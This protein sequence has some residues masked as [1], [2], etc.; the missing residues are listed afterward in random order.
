MLKIFKV[1]TTVSPERQ[2]RRDE[3]RRPPPAQTKVPLAD[4][5]QPS[6]RQVPPEPKHAPPVAPK[7]GTKPKPLPRGSRESLDKLDREPAGSLNDSFEDVPDR[8]S[9]MEKMHAVPTPLAAVLQ[10]S[11][12]KEKAS[13]DED[14]HST[15]R[16]SVDNYSDDMHHQDDRE[17]GRYS[18]IKD[19]NQIFRDNTNS[20]FGKRSVGYNPYSEIPDAQKEQTLMFHT[21]NSSAVSRDK[22]LFSYPS[23]SI[24]SILSHDEYCVEDKDPGSVGTKLHASVHDLSGK[25]RNRYGRQNIGH[26]RSVGNLPTKEPLVETQRLGHNMGV[27]QEIDEAR[28]ETE[29]FRDKSVVNEDHYAEIPARVTNP[30]QRIY[31][32]KSK[33]FKENQISDPLA[34]KLAVEKTVPKPPETNTI[35]KTKPEEPVKKQASFTRKL[36][37]RTS[38]IFKDKQKPKLETSK[39]EVNVQETRK[40]PSVSAASKLEISNVSETHNSQEPGP[41]TLHVQHGPQAVVYAKINKE[42]KTKSKY[43]NQNKSLPSQFDNGDTDT[44]S[45]H[46]DSWNRQEMAEPLV[47]KMPSL[48]EEFKMY[49]LDP[50]KSHSAQSSL[51]SSLSSSVQSRGDKNSSENKR[52]PIIETDNKLEDI[53]QNS[54]ILNS[55]KVSELNVPGNQTANYE[56]PP[57]SGFE[58]RSSDNYTHTLTTAEADLNKGN[59]DTDKNH[60]TG[61]NLPLKTESKYERKECAEKPRVVIGEVVLSETE[62]LDLSEVLHCSKPAVLHKLDIQNSEKLGVA[63]SSGHNSYSLDFDGSINTSAQLGQESG[64]DSMQLLEVHD[65]DLEAFSNLSDDSGDLDLKLHENIADFSMVSTSSSD[66]QNPNEGSPIVSDLQKVNIVSTDKVEAELAKGSSFETDLQRFSDASTDLGIPD[67]T[68]AGRSTGDALQR[69]KTVSEKLGEPVQGHVTESLYTETDLRRFNTVSTDS[70]EFEHV[71][72]FSEGRSTGNDF[73][74]SIFTNSTD[75]ESSEQKLKDRGISARADSQSFSHVSVDLDEVVSLNVSSIDKDSEHCSTVID[76]VSICK[77]KYDDDDVCLENKPLAVNRSGMNY[78]I[79]PSTCMYEAESVSH[80]DVAVDLSS[81]KSDTRTGGGDLE[82][83]TSKTQDSSREYQKAASANMKEVNLEPFVMSEYDSEPGSGFRRKHYDQEN[84]MI[85]ITQ[86]KDEITENRPTTDADAEKITEPKKLVANKDTL[87]LQEN[88]YNSEQRIVDGEDQ[89]T[90]DFFTKPS[91]L[92]DFK[93]I[94]KEYSSQSPFQVKTESSNMEVKLAEEPVYENLKDVK[95]DTEHITETLPSF[96]LSTNEG[97]V[98]KGEK[99]L[100]AG[101]TPL[102]VEQIPATSQETVARRKLEFPLVSDVIETEKRK[103]YVPSSKVYADGNKENIDFNPAEF[104]KQ[105]QSVREPRKT[106]KKSVL[107][108]RPEFSILAGNLSKKNENASP[109]VQPQPKAK[110]IHKKDTPNQPCLETRNQDLSLAENEQSDNKAISLG[111]YGS[112]EGLSKTGANLC[113]DQTSKEDTALADLSDP[114][115]NSFGTNVSGTAKTKSVGTK[116][117]PGV[118]HILNPCPSGWM[119]GGL[120]CRQLGTSYESENRGTSQEQLVSVLDISPAEYIESMVP[121]VVF[122]SLDRNDSEPENKTLGIDTG[123]QSQEPGENYDLDNLPTA[124]L[125]C[126]RTWKYPVSKKLEGTSSKT[127]D[128]NDKEDDF[129]DTD[130]NDLIEDVDTGEQNNSKT[131]PESRSD[132]T[133]CTSGL[134]DT[135]H[136]QVQKDYNENRETSK[137]SEYVENYIESAAQ[138]PNDVKSR[139]EAIGLGN[140]K[141]DEDEFRMQNQERDN[142]EIVYSNEELSESDPSE[143]DS[144]S[145]DEIELVSFEMPKVCKNDPN[146]SFDDYDNVVFDGNIAIDCSFEDVKSYQMNEDGAHGFES[147]ENEWDVLKRTDNKHLV[148]EII[149]ETPYTATRSNLKKRAKSDSSLERKVRFQDNLPVYKSNQN[150]RDPNNPPTRAF[151]TFVDT[152][153]LEKM[154]KI[155]DFITCLF[156]SEPR[157]LGTHPPQTTEND[158]FRNDSNS[159]SPTDYLLENAKNEH[160]EE[161]QAPHQAQGT[162]PLD[163]LDATN[164][165]EGNYALECSAELLVKSNAHDKVKDNGTSTPVLLEHTKQCDSRGLKSFMTEPLDTQLRVKPDFAHSGNPVTDIQNIGPENT[166]TNLE[167]T[168][169]DH[170]IICLQTT[171][172]EN[173]ASALQLNNEIPKTD[174]MQTTNENSVTDMQTSNENPITDMQT[175]HE[176]PITDMQT[177]NESTSTES[178]NENSVDMQIEAQEKPF[179]QSPNTEKVVKGSPQAHVTRYCFTVDDSDEESPTIKTVTYEYVT[180]YKLNNVKIQYQQNRKTQTEDTVFTSLPLNSL[181]ERKGNS[182][183][184]KDD[185][186]AIVVEEVIEKSVCYPLGP[187]HGLPSSFYDRRKLTPNMEVHEEIDK[188]VKVTPPPAIVRKQLKETKEIEVGPV[189]NIEDGMNTP[190]SSTKCY[191]KQKAEISTIEEGSEQREPVKEDQIEKSVFYELHAV[192]PKTFTRKFQKRTTPQHKHVVEHNS[193]KYVWRSLT[194]KIPFG[195]TK[196]EG[197]S[198]LESCGEK[199]TRKDMCQKEKNEEASICELPKRCSFKTPPE[200]RIHGSVTSDQR[201]G[202]VLQ[203]GMHENA[204]AGLEGSHSDSHSGKKMKKLDVSPRCH[205]DEMDHDKGSV[206]EVKEVLDSST[207]DTYV[208]VMQERLP[209][210]TVDEQTEERVFVMQA[211]AVIGLSAVLVFLLPYV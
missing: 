140:V 73:Q 178:T 168:F 202:T 113:G 109:G 152:D 205:D 148:P 90:M 29:P 147:L 135:L 82:T 54:G 203:K 61:E 149:D 177:V 176:N 128:N 204:T 129:K 124:D 85:E 102:K 87:E 106:Q 207:D 63:N 9:R 84:D 185:S 163:N 36:F 146:A 92:D 52:K 108:L 98:L 18:Q 174:Y 26:S 196:Q 186:T 58:N 6:P 191:E 45:T 11:M 118:I 32:R 127:K 104:F 114:S 70:G 161:N 33:H 65:S 136:E 120:K 17:V 60:T 211:L 154:K 88:I 59:I 55:Q 143:T 95:K 94:K 187:I 69:L 25:G 139:L 1:C 64:N 164:N 99:E 47:A 181:K 122:S 50:S 151:N 38:K 119:E 76:S 4:S 86:K 125:L 8:K 42:Q 197:K 40:K 39:S 206:E 35:P 100:V 15:D 160:Q 62:E 144:D 67:N 14:R 188:S 68:T 116:M 150:L 10:K 101:E 79:S 132:C 46:S 195:D 80:Q 115:L 179:S 134:E 20:A 165:T 126:K 97:G 199:A 157:K 41:H 21:T 51:D 198:E 89:Q 166:T 28:T 182:N 74:R 19:T 201:F 49:L 180:E 137:A 162:I 53:A 83:L 123:K 141:M 159:I 103:V 184:E 91:T 171:N 57:R 175:S 2:Q 200:I 37:E 192:R 170:N 48:R 169:P 208:A 96:R 117:T 111:E 155:E 12:E 56:Y 183:I 34:Q 107:P 24:D 23:S 13:I 158:M 209:Y 93:N 153:E 156:E 131:S 138:Y 172:T 16:H 105:S 81:P 27:Y 7:P 44:Q 77:N 189:I 31:G 75:L 210:L 110:L 167:T 30:P 112:V 130:I 43:N 145:G 78:G 5:P 193:T 194:T 71:H 173:L 133:D 190:V 142:V 72:D 22:Y 66:K 121:D 3:L